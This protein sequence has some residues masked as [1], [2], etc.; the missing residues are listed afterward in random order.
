[1]KELI[2]LLVILTSQMCDE[3]SQDLKFLTSMM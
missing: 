1:M 2:K 3:D